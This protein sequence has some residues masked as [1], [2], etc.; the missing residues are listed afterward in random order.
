MWASTQRKLGVSKP[1]LCLAHNIVLIP[2][3][4]QIN[5]LAKTKVKSHAYL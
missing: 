5:C 3:F 1:P 4:W 2:E